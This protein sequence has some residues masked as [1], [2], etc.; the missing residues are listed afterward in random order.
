V[1]FGFAIGIPPGYD[2]GARTDDG[3]TFTAVGGTLVLSVRGGSVLPGSF[4]DVWR[5]TQSS[6]RDAGW[7]LRYEPTPPNWTSFEGARGDRLLYVKMIPLCGGTKQYAMFALEY[8]G[9]DAAA[10]DP[11]I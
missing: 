9:K 8:P 1:R 2:D 11:T 4:D 3:Q 10:L 7:M 5:E 6:Y